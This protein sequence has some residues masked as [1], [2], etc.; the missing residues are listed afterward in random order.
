MLPSDGV[1]GVAAQLALKGL[2]SVSV[3]SKWFASLKQFKNT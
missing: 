1:K 3:W 2:L